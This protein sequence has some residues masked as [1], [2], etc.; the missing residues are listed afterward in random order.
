MH[1]EA[2]VQHEVREEG[3]KALDNPQ[4]PHLSDTWVLSLSV[5]FQAEMSE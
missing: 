2:S 5:S 4:R 3:F 1:S